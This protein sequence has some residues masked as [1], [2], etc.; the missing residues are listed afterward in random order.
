MK[1]RVL[2]AVPPGARRRGG[3]TCGSFERGE[4]ER[5]KERRSVRIRS[6]R[7][8]AG[9]LVTGVASGTHTHNLQIVAVSAGL[10]P[11]PAHLDGNIDHIAAILAEL[12]GHRRP[13][14]ALGPL[15]L[16]VPE[17]LVEPTGHL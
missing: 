7:S 12:D 5:E 3:V 10:V 17:R 9:R 4:R 8:S 1:F 15:L 11:R 14:V 16:A 2:S 13:L 6:Q